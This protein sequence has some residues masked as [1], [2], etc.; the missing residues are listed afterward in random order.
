MY[1]LTVNTVNSPF[2]K[3]KVKKDPLVLI[4]CKI[5]KIK[6]IY[7]YLVSSI[8][9]FTNEY[10]N[11]PISIFSKTKTRIKKLRSIFFNLFLKKK[12]K[13]KIPSCLFSHVI[14]NRAFPCIL[15]LNYDEMEFESID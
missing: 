6:N 9:N 8:F 15:F 14:H 10:R 12:K 13:E 1:N 2:A 7:I 3:A 11:F 4:Y 5:I